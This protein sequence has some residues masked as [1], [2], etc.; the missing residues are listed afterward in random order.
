M[1]LYMKA[2]VDNGKDN[3]GETLP[4]GMF[5]YIAKDT[6]INAEKN[7]S[8]EKIKADRL[9]SLKMDGIFLDDDDATNALEPDGQGLYSPVV[10]KK[11]GSFASNSHYYTIEQYKILSDYIDL[12]LKETANEMVSGDIAPKPLDSTTYG[13]CDYCD[14]ADVCQF[15]GEHDK[16]PKLKD[17]D[18]FQF[19][20]DRLNKKGE[21]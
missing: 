2:V 7:E 11:D 21:D 19:M 1:P 16:I 10:R 12:K 4:G 9:K 14:Y 15:K 18:A 6:V 13:A 8:N 17:V 3:F 20:Y 5:Y